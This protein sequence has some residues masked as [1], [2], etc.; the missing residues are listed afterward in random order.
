[1]NCGFSAK[2]KRRTMPQLPAAALRWRRYANARGYIVRLH[3][4]LFSEIPI[5]KEQ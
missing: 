5:I 1:V 4:A 2:V 3:N